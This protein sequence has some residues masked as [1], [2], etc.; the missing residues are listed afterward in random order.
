M[1]AFAYTR[2]TSI[3][4]AISALK[5]DPEAKV[6]AGGQ[7]LLPSLKLRLAAPKQLIDLRSI[8]ELRGINSNGDQLVIGAMTTH[9]QVATDAA[10][11]TKLPALAHLAGGIGDRMV[12]N[13]GT[14]GGSIAN[15]DPAACYPA[16]LLALDAT[17]VTSARRIPAAQFFRGLFET[18]L[19]PDELVTAVEFPAVTRAAYIK[20]RHPASRFAMVGVFVAD[21][22]NGPRVAVTGAAACVFRATTLEVALQ[23]QF[24]AAAVRGMV[25]DPSTLN[26][27]M[28]A[29]AAYRANL[30]SVL[31]ERAVSRATRV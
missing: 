19:Q 18:A 17:V 3:A 28:H 16:A 24:S 7:T 1:Y 27:D 21:T 10:V 15:N 14:L 4:T 31:T 2:A 23:K 8:A 5:D 30:I 29:S 20:F 26:S 11:M 13:L 12:R 22:R 6:L 25:V 9:A